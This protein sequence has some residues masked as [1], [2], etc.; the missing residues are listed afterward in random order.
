MSERTSLFIPFQVTN[1]YKTRSYMSSHMG[2]PTSPRETTITY[3]MMLNW[4]LLPQITIEVVPQVL[5]TI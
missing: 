3:Y 1:Q 2:G 5:D 4:G